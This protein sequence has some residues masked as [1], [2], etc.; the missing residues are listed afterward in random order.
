MERLPECVVSTPRAS[1][2]GRNG[3]RPARAVWALQGSCGQPS[4]RGIIPV[5]LQEAQDSGVPSCPMG[6]GLS[7]LVPLLPQVREG[8]T[9]PCFYNLFGSLA[10]CVFPNDTKTLVP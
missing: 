8:V 7:T 6:S 1:A 10:I 2:C 3:W 5:N 9:G 4:L